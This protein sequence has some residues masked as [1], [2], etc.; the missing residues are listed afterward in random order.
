MIE[1]I[2]AIPLENTDDLHA[3]IKE[4]IL[5]GNPFLATP[6][7]LKD[8][9]RHA[10]LVL[11][12][13]RTW[14]AFDRSVTR[15]WQITDR[16]GVYKIVPQRLYSKRGGWVPENDA[17]ISLPAGTDLDTACGAII[18]IMKAAES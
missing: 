2:A 13:T 6:F 15:T 1:P 5:A 18:E 3:A 8:K 14:G 17:A 12:G 10:L 11:A 4:K 9:T 16:D 7:P